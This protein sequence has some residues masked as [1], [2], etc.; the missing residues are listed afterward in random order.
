M[1]TAVLDKLGMLGIGAALEVDRRS[2]VFET[3]NLL[4]LERLEVKGSVRSSL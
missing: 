4:D 3:D 2:G 1:K